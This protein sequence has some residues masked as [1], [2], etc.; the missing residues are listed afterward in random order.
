M[1]RAAPRII[2]IAI[3]SNV[4]PGIGGN[5]SGTEPKV[6]VEVGDVV[7]IVED[8]LASKVTALDVLTMVVGCTTAVEVVEVCEVLLLVTV[9]V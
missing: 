9:V 1:A 5:A 2:P 8:V 7:L 4:N 6:E 3:D